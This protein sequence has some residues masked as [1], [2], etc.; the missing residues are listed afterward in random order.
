MNSSQN[1][2]TISVDALLA[3]YRYLSA[4]QPGILV[5]PVLKSNA[6]G[7]GLSLVGKI[8]DKVNAPFFCLNTIDEAEELV[9][10]DIK[11]PLLVMGPVIPQ[12]L[13]TKKFPFS[14]AVYDESFVAAMSNYQP[15]AGIHIF[16]D[17]GMCR[18]GIPLSDLPEF[19]RFLQS[20][21]NLKVEGLM[22]HLAVGESATLAKNQIKKFEE[23][24]N[25]VYNAGIIP[26]WFHQ[27]ASGAILHNKTFSGKIGNLARVG[28]ALYGIDPLVRDKKLQPVLQFSSVLTQI[29][30]LHKGEKVG[31]DFT[32]TAPRDMIIGVVPAGYFDGIDRR[33]SNTGYVSVKK[34]F[35]PIVGRISMNFTTID[36][37]TVRD[38]KVGDPVALYSGNFPDKNS[39]YCA[40]QL[41]G[42][43]PYDIVAGLP[44]STKRVVV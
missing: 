4:L 14:Y 31:Y 17:T 3:N 2:I 24:K 40:A 20:F 22:T 29:K 21:K 28:I 36:I 25:V 9:K 12:I 5:A 33:L 42:T 35:C 1:S 15:Q 37:S 10:N 8:L 34:K 16:V 19:L 18:E 26:K 41:S 32:Y 23:A 13:K 7:H 44:S 6:Y 27:G 43:I 11:T 30:F 39:V 38:P